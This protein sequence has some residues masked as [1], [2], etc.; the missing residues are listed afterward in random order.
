M[1]RGKALC[2]SGCRGGWQG[3]GLEILREVK[4]NEGLEE[5]IRN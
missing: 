2:A 1:G 3:R 5:T 4:G